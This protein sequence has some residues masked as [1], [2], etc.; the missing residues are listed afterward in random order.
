MHWYFQASPKGMVIT[1]K[2]A[3]VIHRLRQAQSSLISRCKFILRPSNSDHGID[4][5]CTLFSL[6][7]SLGMAAVTW[8]ALLTGYL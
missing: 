4:D 3:K 7:T 2:L 6:K 5:S 8:W 1:H